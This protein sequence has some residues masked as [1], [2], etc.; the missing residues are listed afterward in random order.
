MIRRPPGPTRTD[1]L[2]PYT[3]LFRSPA[4]KCAPL[5]RPHRAADA[6]AAG[7]GAQ[8]LRRA[9]G[10]VPRHPDEGDAGADHLALGVDP[11]A[12]GAAVRDRYAPRPR[13]GRLGD[14]KSVV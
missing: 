12:P 7:H 2:F 4:R 14:R 9:I 3:T 11:A 13:R 5:A 10:P 1:T 8:R 6:G